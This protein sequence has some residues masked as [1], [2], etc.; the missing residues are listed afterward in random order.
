LAQGPGVDGR[1]IFRGYGLQ[2]I[3]AKGRVA[4]PAAL[5]STIE[6]NSGEKFVV[7]ARH[8]QDPCLIAYDRGYSTILHAE[9][10]AREAEERAAG[11]AAARFNSNRA[12]FGA[13]DDVAFDGSGRFVIPPFL[14][15]RGQLGDLAFFMAAGDTFEIWNPQ[16]FLAA[17]TVAEE[18]KDLCRF[19]LEERGIAA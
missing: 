3:D 4:I 5:R 16:V 6:Q 2:A 13:V 8:E 15:S 14:K 10:K 9:M 18:F 1:V 7:L 12:A 17:D 19:T 11:R